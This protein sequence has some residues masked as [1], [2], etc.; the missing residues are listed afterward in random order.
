MAYEKRAYQVDEQDGRFEL[1]EYAPAVLAETTV[2][3]DFEDV[4]STAFRILAAYIGGENE[5]RSSIAM[6]APVT[7]EP[8]SQK[9]AMTA[10]VT[11][12]SAD[13]GY[14]VSFMMPAGSTLENLPTPKDPRV[15]LREDPP[16]RYAAVTYSGFWSREK[17]E[18]QLGELR[19]WI[20]ERGLEPTGEPVWARYD[21][22]FMPWFLRTN[23]ILIEVTE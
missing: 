14:R 18:R 2:Q 11:Q 9:I 22:P 8:L 13:A 3:G 12:Q 19:R 6:T 23:E 10:P 1:R 17:Y 4:G 16:G 20:D 7:Q 15:A 5:D 21:P